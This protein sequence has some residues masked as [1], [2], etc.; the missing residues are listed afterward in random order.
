MIK[1]IS[2]YITGF[3]FGFIVAACIEDYINRK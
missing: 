2:G 3:I 1:F